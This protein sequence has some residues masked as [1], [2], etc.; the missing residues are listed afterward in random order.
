MTENIFQIIY[1]ISVLGITHTYILF[2][3]MLKIMAKGKSLNY[4]AY[5]DTDKNLPTISILLSI[6]NEEA[7][8]KEK[9]ES[10]FNTTYPIDKIEFLI[11][12]DRS[13]D[14]SNSMILGLKSKYPGI[15][16]FPFNI[17]QGKQNVINCLSKEATGSIFILTDANVFFDR[18]TLFQIIKYF[19]D[20]DIGLVDTRMFHRGITDDG[21]S[22]QESRYI[23]REVSIKQH[24]SILW[25]TMMGPF[26]GCYAV[27]RSLY[28][29]VPNN[30]LVDDFYI[31][32]QV[33]EQGFYAVNNIQAK[34][35]EDVSNNLW[36]EFRRKIRIATGNFQNLKTFW[37]LL[38]NKSR[39]TKK[40]LKGLAYT[41]FS[42]KLLRW[43]T[44]FLIIIALIVNIFLLNKILYFVLIC[45]LGSTFIIPFIDN[46]LKKFSVHFSLF[47]FITHFYSM[48]IALV[49][50]F[51][52]FLKGVKSGVWKP[53]KRNQST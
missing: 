49:I 39:Y 42:H 4:E 28:K 24:E 18:N 33:L 8:I 23:S 22:F 26:G 5:N 12:S 35:Y 48:N 47:R 46:I 3:L 51:F 52:R 15:R 14:K 17:R 13:S 21:I 11:G 43:I 41:F 1:W 45:G 38:I 16:F 30:F 9:I 37:H 36:D 34:V 53:T 2:P 27:R 44:P 29:P 19:K 6:Y 10:V 7:V 32:M 31:N 50:G 20:N 25:G 40:T